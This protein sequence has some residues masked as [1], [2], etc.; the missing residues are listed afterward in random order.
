MRRRVGNLP[1][2]SDW[3]AYFF[4]ELHPEDL[5]VSEDPDDPNTNTALSTEE[6]TPCLAGLLEL[7]PWLSRWH[8]EFDVLYSGLPGGLLRRLPPAEGGRARTHG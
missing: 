1:E 5:R 7:H 8:D 6:I 3:Q 4:Y 2:E